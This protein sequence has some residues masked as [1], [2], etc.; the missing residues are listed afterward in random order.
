MK[1]LILD[2]NVLLTDPRSLYVFEENEIIKPVD[3][4]PYK[5]KNIKTGQKIPAPINL[6]P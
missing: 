1:T 2:T 4:Y 5:L 6:H 3:K